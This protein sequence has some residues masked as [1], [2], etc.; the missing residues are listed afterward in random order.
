MSV[1]NTGQDGA[2]GFEV[3]DVDPAGAA[4]VPGSLELLTGPGGPASPTDA[5]GDDVAELDA[6]NNRSR[7][8]SGRA[9]TRP[10]AG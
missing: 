9:R 10:R 6:A 5:G 7:S 3:T 1:E 2:T 4:F 8:G